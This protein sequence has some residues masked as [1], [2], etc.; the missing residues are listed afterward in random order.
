MKTI[1]YSVEITTKAGNREI[2]GNADNIKAARKLAKVMAT[3]FPTR[4]MAGGPGG[5]EVR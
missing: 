3:S 1:F 2:A 4:I 5:M